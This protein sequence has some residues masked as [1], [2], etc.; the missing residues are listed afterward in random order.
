MP[1]RLVFAML[2]VLTAFGGSTAVAG[3]ALLF[4]PVDGKILYGEDID[5]LWHPAS[6]TKVLTAYLT[7]EAIRDGRVKLDTKIACSDRAFA[8]PP[9]KVGLPVGAE[10]TVETALHALIIKSANDVAV[11]L[12]EAVDGSEAEFVAR[13]NRTAQRL[14]MSRTTF[15]NP[16]GLPAIQQVTTARD[17]A[18]LARA[19][20]KEFPEYSSYWSMSDM[21]IGKMRLGSHNALLKSFPGADGMK[22]G[23]IC[24]SGF[25][26][27]ASATRDGRKLMAVVLGEPTGQDRTIR[28][29]S[30]LEH[31]FQNQSWKQ[32]FN[33]E[34]IDNVPISPNARR[35][36]SMRAS[37]LSWECGTG[38]G[39]PEVA[40][41]K[42]RIKALNAVPKSKNKALVAAKTDPGSVS[43]DAAAKV[44]PATSGHSPAS[45]DEQPKKK[46]KKAAVQDAAEGS[47]TAGA[48]PKT[49]P[50]AKTPAAND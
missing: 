5:D 42:A 48:E 24:D 34:T 9:S 20:L 26:V 18:K 22:T 7:F 23:F 1:Y 17:L 35:V 38:R 19:V 10:L 49:A 45:A 47:G 32:M 27:I 41:R 33:T 39:N 50:A 37:V 25:N 29:A 44:K 46:Q 28:A 8:Q 3:P 31:G 11:M 2:L 6:V 12:A 15:S 21:R 30:L 43:V 40:A 16:N 36:Q 14:G 13:M 4:D